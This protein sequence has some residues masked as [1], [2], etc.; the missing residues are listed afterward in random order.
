MQQSTPRRDSINP[1]RAPSI[2]GASK[3]SYLGRTLRVRWLAGH[4]SGSMS[5]RRLAHPVITD[6][7]MATLRAPRDHGQRLRAGHRIG[8]ACRPDLAG[9][10]SRGRGTMAAHQPPPA[11]RL[12]N[13]AEQ[14]IEGVVASPDADLKSSTLTGTKLAT[15]PQVVENMADPEARSRPRCRRYCSRR[16]TYRD[17]QGIARSKAGLRGKTAIKQMLRGI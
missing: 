15:L 6:R 16:R 9:D 10:P 7:P 8:D 3:P 11:S 13:H 4:R 14:A 12:S 2:T 1:P 5:R 17:R